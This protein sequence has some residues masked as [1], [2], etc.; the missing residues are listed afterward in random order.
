[1]SMNPMLETSVNLALDEGEAFLRWL[2]SQPHAGQYA[3][4]KTDDEKV[5]RLAQNEIMIAL[6]RAIRRAQRTVGG[7]Q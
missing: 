1:M 3:G 7:G 2:R 4:A 5:L 6:E